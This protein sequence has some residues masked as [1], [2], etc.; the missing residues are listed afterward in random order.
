[1]LYEFSLFT[2]N[3][4]FPLIVKDIFTLK[5]SDVSFS[6]NLLRCTSSTEALIW[7]DLINV[8]LTHLRQSIS[9]N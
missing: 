9:V 2:K 3:C 5:I 6:S 8:T 1:M 4:T 7:A